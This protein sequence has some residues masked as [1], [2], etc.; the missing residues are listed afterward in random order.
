M[1]FHNL[2]SFLNMGGYAAYV[3]PAYGLA[4]VILFGNAFATKFK[5]RNAKQQVQRKIK[6]LQHNASSS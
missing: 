1:Y 6:Q 4:A 5:H 2:H 3:W